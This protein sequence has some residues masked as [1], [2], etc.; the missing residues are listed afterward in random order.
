MNRCVMDERHLVNFDRKGKWHGAL[1]LPRS[2]MKVQANH[3]IG[4]C[5][6]L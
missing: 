6:E 1:I 3:I 2:M 4:S 5:D